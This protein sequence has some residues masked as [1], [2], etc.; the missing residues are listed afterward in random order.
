MLLESG[1]DEERETAIKW[2]AN[3]IYGGGTDPVSGAKAYILTGY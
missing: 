2:A 1:L 3:S